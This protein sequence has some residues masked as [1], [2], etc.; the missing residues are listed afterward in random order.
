MATYAELYTLSSNND[1]LNRTTVS[2]LIAAE[3]IRVEDDQTANHANRL[4]WARAVLSNADR[5]AR[6]VLWALLVQ[7]R[8]LTVAQLTGV[9]D[10]ALQT[11]VNTAVLS[12]VRDLVE[13]P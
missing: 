3:A 12:F 7:N 4:Q 11:S 2:I 10:S 6:R 5:E 8:T 9:T 1:L 13:T